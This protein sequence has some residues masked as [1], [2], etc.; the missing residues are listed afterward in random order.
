MPLT[1][2]DIRVEIK[3]ESN[4]FLYATAVV[5]FD[6]LK[7]SGW[8]ISKSKFGDEPWVQ[9]PSILLGNK[10]GKPDYFSVIHLPTLE[11]GM[12]VQ[13]IIEEYRKT[14]GGETYDTESS[15]R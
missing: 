11:W 10:G 13:K 8:R 14:K 6:Y 2:E 3:L 7:V 9:A 15:F 12:V 1:S 4:D 5:Y